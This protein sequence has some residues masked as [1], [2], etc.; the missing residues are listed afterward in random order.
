MNRSGVNWTYAYNELSLPTTA[1][2]ALDSRTY[3]QGYTYSN[4]AALTGYTLLSGKAVTQGVDGLGRV[5]S[6]TVDSTGIASGFSYH[7]NGSV[8]GVN[9]GNGQVF[10]QTLTPRQQTDRLRSVLGG[11]LP[12]DLTYAYKPRS[13]IASVNDQTAANIDQAFTYDGVGRLTA[14]TGPWGIGTF[15]YDGL[16]NIRQRAVGSRTVGMSYNAANQLSAHTDTA[17]VVLAPVTADTLFS[18]EAEE[19]S[20]K[21]TTSRKRTFE[22]IVETGRLGPGH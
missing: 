19:T 17:L 22:T 2:L 6:V 21:P 16:G 18:R 7:P 8:A 10:S 15:Q 20:V 14:S 1:T 3:A 9:Y 11:E 12:V 13:Q 5:T 4:A